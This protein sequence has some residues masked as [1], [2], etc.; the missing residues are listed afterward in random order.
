MSLTYHYWGIGF[1]VPLYPFIHPDICINATDITWSGVEQGRAI[2]SH[3]EFLCGLHSKMMVIIFGGVHKWIVCFQCKY[4]TSWSTHSNVV[5]NTAVEVMDDGH[6]STGWIPVVLVLQH[7]QL[8]AK[9]INFLQSQRIQI[10]VCF[11]H[12]SYKPS[13]IWHKYLYPFYYVC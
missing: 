9:V 2:S 3:Q 8:T 6:L 7:K 1:L 5:P 12:Q 13:H 4:L 11:V 10:I